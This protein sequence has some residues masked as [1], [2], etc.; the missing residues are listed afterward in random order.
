MKCN[1]YNIII[2]YILQFTNIKNMKDILFDV[3][4]VTKNTNFNLQGEFYKSNFGNTTYEGS[5]EQP[6]PGDINSY[7]L[8]CYYWIQDPISH[9]RSYHELILPYGYK[10]RALYMLTD[11]KIF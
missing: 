9:I 3:F 7:L 6:Q 10:I 2:G 5:S 1:I 8:P 4:L 11:F